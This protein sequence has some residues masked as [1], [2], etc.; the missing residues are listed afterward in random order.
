MEDEMSK[1]TW[2]LHQQRFFTRRQQV[3]YLVQPTINLA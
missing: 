1:E 3:S 2:G